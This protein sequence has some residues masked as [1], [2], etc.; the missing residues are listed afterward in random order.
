MTNDEFEKTCIAF[1][2]NWNNRNGCYMNTTIAK[3]TQQCEWINN[4]WEETS[5]KRKA[6]ANFEKS[7]GECL[8]NS[9]HGIKLYTDAAVLPHS[10]GQVM[11]S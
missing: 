11:V 9:A 1:W 5:Y 4:Y 7:A 3:W 8:A 10:K 6:E 2:S